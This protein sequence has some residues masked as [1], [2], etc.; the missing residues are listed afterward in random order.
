MPND[1]PGA[2]DRAR[3][4]AGIATPNSG[5][6]DG[7][8][9]WRAVRALVDAALEL[10][11]PARAAFLERAGGDAA[12]RADAARWLAACERAESAG[13]FLVRPAAERAAALF[14]TDPASDTSSIADAATL[15]TLRNALG[16]AYEVERE[17]GRGGMAAVYLARDLRHRRRVP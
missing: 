9:R 1:D 15:A 11:A 12:V 2:S 4:A 17:L 6:G 7:S 10:P 5:T 8:E 3:A 13:D 14:P 16:D